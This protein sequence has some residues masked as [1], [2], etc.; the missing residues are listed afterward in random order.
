[1]GSSGCFHRSLEGFYVPIKDASIAGNIPEMF[2]AATRVAGDRRILSYMEA[3]D[4]IF[5]SLG[6]SYD[7]AD[8][9]AIAS[10][11]ELLQLCPGETPSFLKVEEQM[12]DSEQLWGWVHVTGGR[13]DGKAAGVLNGFR[14]F[15][16]VLTWPN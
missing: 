10:I 1:V 2:L 14:E 9:K 6:H 3:L 11:N 7:Q 13:A 4:I 15:R 8:G 12:L 16:G 5:A